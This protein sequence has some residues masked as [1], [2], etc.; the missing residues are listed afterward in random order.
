M[1]KEYAANK[2]E[3]MLEDA[4]ALGILYAASVGKEYT[5]TGMAP[6]LY[7]P[8]RQPEPRE[9][10]YQRYW[11]APL[12]AVSANPDLGIPEDLPNRIEVDAFTL[13]QDDKDVDLKSKVKRLKLN[14]KNL[15]G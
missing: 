6:D 3:D 15:E 1:R 9:A 5:L 11:T 13:A 7:G 12:D 14:F 10:Y 4:E 8:G 2:H